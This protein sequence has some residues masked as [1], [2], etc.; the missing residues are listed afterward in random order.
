MNWTISSS[1]APGWNTAATPSLFNYAASS[2][3]TTPPIVRERI[4]A[5]STM[6]S[7][8]SAISGAFGRLNGVI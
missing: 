2:F 8:A 4:P 6:R 3:G 1:E 5:V 7:I